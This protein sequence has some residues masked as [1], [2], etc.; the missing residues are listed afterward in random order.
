MYKGKTLRQPHIDNSICNVIWNHIY[1]FLIRT[2][3]Y[4]HAAAALPLGK[5]SL[6]LTEEEAFEKSIS[7]TP[8]E[9]Q[10]STPYPVVTAVPELPA[11]SVPMTVVL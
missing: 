2:V 8:V 6:V 7:L 4:F 10:T 1:P 3:Q 11:P 5:N 9:N